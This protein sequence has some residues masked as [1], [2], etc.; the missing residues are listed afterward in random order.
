M[1]N[2]LGATSDAFCP[3]T[4]SEQQPGDVL[5][6]GAG[7]RVLGGRLYAVGGFGCY[8]MHAILRAA[9]R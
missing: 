8:S 9:L 5:A 4:R 2:D 7:A 6:P 3:G 1:F